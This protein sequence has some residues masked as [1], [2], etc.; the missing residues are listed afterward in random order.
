MVDELVERLFGGD[1][2][3]LVSHLINDDRIDRG[4]LDQLRERLAEAQARETG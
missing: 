1:P 2:A 3:A 4:E